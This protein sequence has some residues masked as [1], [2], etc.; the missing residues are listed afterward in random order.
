MPTDLITLSADGSV[1]DLAVRAEALGYDCLWTGELWGRDSLVALTAAAEATEGIDLGTA[2]VNTYGRTPATLAQAAAT[3]QRISGGRFRLGLGTSTGKVVE[4]L[5]G[6][7]FENPPRRFHET[8]ELTRRFLTG[9]GR[10]EYDGQVFSVADFPSLETDVPVYGAALGPAM[11]RAVGR[12]VDGWLPHNIPF[13][14]LGAAFETVA[15]AAREADRDPADITVAPY[16]PSAVSEDPEEAV[17]TVRGHI[18]YYVGSGAGYRAA[19]AAHY[20][21][22]DEIA[23]AWQAGDRAGAREAVTD[24]MV[25]GLAVAG[26][27]DRAREQFDDIAALDVVDRPIVAVPGG[28]S[29]AVTDRT[30]ETLA[31]ARR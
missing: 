13:H 6:M 21:G 1:S 2:I 17:E 20:E 10:I 7:A 11:R 15:E 12:T 9:E 16:V 14:D 30:V 8:A 18:A 5:H 22:T 25:E 28:A 23:A 24:E 31:P 27:P 26:T 29:D 4:D 19:V 3:I